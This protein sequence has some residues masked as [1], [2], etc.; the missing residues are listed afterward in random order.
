MGYASC[1]WNRQSIVCNLRLGVYNIIDFRVYIKVVFGVSN[2]I[3]FG[4]YT[5]INFGVYIK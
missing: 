1:Q 5:I 4:V 3:V 2:I